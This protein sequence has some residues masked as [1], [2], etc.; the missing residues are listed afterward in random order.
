MVRKVPC[1]K[2]SSPT[3]SP[4]RMR[5]S[6]GWASR[7]GC[8]V[9]K[10]RVKL[11]KP[12]TASVQ[13][14]RGHTMKRLSTR[15]PPIPDFLPAERKISRRQLIDQVARN[16]APPAVRATPLRLPHEALEELSDLARA[17]NI[18]RNALICQ[19]IDSG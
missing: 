16:E 19:L 14:W 1:S 11:A 15:T 6:L 3:A 10:L 7:S 9:A 8:Q 4:F 18:S 2:V 12:S 13:F 5:W 17:E